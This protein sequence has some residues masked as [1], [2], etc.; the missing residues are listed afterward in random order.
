MQPHHSPLSNTYV[1]LSIFGMIVAAAIWSLT[2]S[3]GFLILLFSIITFIASFISAVRAPLKS[4]EEIELAVHERYHGRRYPDTDLHHGHVPAQKKYLHTRHKKKL[5]HH[6]VSSEESKKT[7]RKSKSSKKASTRKSTKKSAS[8]RKTPSKKS[9][10]KA[11]SKKSS[12]RAAK[13]TKKSSR[14]KR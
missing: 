2:P 9:T 11:A 5:V 10:R 3:W 14:K 7:K 1:L 13:K 8:K 12:K 4:D 6:H